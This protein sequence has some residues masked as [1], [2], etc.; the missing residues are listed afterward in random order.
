MPSRR[1]GILSCLGFIGT[2][3][4]LAISVPP[5]L[6]ADKAK[7]SGGKAK[8]TSSA[9]KQAAEA[10]RDEPAESDDETPKKIV[11]TDAEWRKQLTPMQFRV[12]RKKATEIAGTGKYAH[13]KKD[14]IYRC[15]CCGQ[16]LF[17]SKTKFD[18]GTGWPSFF[19]PLSEKA[20]NYIDD[21]SAEELRVEVE[22]SRCDAHLGHVFED[23]PPPTGRRYC[24][25]SASLNLVTRDAIEKEAKA[26]AA[27]AK[28]AK[29]A[30]SQADGGDKSDKFDKS[31]TSKDDKDAKAEKK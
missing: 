20:V 29:E 13:T 10:S 26:K 14:G 5:N 19:Q 4:A 28:E 22:C 3:V 15:I 27:K 17:D 8:G 1:V 7:T 12:A 18:S 11:K 23:G 30:K 24:M 25:N 2:I 9:K 6:A 21:Y 31:A 16:P